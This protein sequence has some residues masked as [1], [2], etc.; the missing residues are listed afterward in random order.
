M[1]TA[2]DI[3]NIE[4]P[5][6]HIAKI[7]T[8]SSLS[9][10]TQLDYALGYE[11]GSKDRLH[12]RILQSDGNGKYNACWWSL[13]SI[14]QSLSAVPAEGAFTISELRPVFAG[15]STNTLYFVLAA[16]LDCGLLHRSDTVTNGYVRNTPT[17]L[18][19]ELQG[20]IQARTNLLPESMAKAAAPIA[21]AVPKAVAKKP[22]KLTAA[23][24]Q[25]G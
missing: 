8:C 17:N 25:N 1:T 21:L 10:L 18:L 24:V 22:P 2:T 11:V 14:E 7:A 3:S 16:L 6:I 19:A 15:R 4:V 12:I 9:G 5:I 20:L 13:A 23:G